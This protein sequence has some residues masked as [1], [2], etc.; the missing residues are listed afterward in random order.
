M[1]TSND[2]NGVFVFRSFGIGLDKIFDG[3]VGIK[4]SGKN[5]FVGS[6]FFFFGT[7]S[8]AGIQDIVHFFQINFFRREIKR[9]VIG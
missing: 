1:V 4:K 3:C 5:I 8:S 9:F 6:D 2:E 7:Q